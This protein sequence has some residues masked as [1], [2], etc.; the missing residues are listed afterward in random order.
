MYAYK[1]IER[2]SILSLH[3]CKLKLELQ[4]CPVQHVLADSA[5]RIKCD[6]CTLSLTLNPVTSGVTQFGKQEAAAAHG[7]HV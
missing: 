7:L 1:G 5:G 6:L 2:I 3:I 4:T